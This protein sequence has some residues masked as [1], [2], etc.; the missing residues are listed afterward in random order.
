MS[1]VQKHKKERTAPYSSIFKFLFFLILSLFSF[2]LCPF[3]QWSKKSE[4][5]YK[6]NHAIDIALQLRRASEGKLWEK[7]FVEPDLITK[8]IHEATEPSFHLTDLFQSEVNHSRKRIQPPTDS[9]NYKTKSQKQWP[10][11]YLKILHKLYQVQIPQTFPASTLPLY[12]RQNKSF[13]TRY[14]HRS[15]HTCYR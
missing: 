6:G 12:L 9:R 10:V 2:P 14:G 5:T 4:T 8:L 1:C 3:L 11:T 15:K 7:T 13:E